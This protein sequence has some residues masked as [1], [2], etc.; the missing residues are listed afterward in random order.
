M[1]RWLRSAPSSFKN[2]NAKYKI[3]LAPG[4]FD[5]FIFR[6]RVSKYRLSTEVTMYSAAWI[7]CLAAMLSVT[8]KD[9]DCAKRQENGWSA[10]AQHF[11]G[12]IEMCTAD[13]SPVCASNGVEYG[14]FCAFCRAVQDGEVPRGASFAYG[15]C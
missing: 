9:G 13:F 8:V 10:C 2:V 7:L 12:A 15:P 11:K 5:I 14:N 3:V 4:V 1:C 6:F